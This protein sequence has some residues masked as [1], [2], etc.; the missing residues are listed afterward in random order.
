MLSVPTTGP[1]CNVWDLYMGCA[2]T[3]MTMALH[4][5]YDWFW[6]MQL[7]ALALPVASIALAGVKVDCCQLYGVSMEQRCVCSMM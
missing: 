5:Y 1:A 7:L 3:M 6:M 2:V 4:F